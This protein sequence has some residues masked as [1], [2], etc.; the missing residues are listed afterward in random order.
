MRVAYLY[1]RSDELEALKDFDSVLGIEG[2]PFLCADFSARMAQQFSYVIACDTPDYHTF[3]AHI[4]AEIGV[5]PVTK[6]TSII[7]PNTIVRPVYGGAIMGTYRITVQP[8]LLT[9]TV[10]ISAHQD[11]G[12][13]LRDARIVVGGGKGMGSKEQFDLI[14]EL[15]EVLGGT[16]GASLDAIQ[17]GWADADRQIG[18]TG[19]SIG[20]DL[21]LACGISGAA[22]HVGGIRMAKTIVAINTNPHAPIFHHADYGYVGDAV[23]IVP[24]LIRRFKS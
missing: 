12:A 18:Q 17:A 3:M 10:G 16:Y 6:I 24:E 5:Q 22:H 23:Q 13:S 11:P 15:A 8:A 4:G 7:D 14:A 1:T 20:P 21:Y 19:T 2:E 9:V